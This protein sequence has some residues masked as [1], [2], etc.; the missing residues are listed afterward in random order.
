MTTTDEGSTASEAA[1]AA[2]RDVVLLFRQLRQ[3][4]REIPEGGLTSAQGAVLLRLDKD[5]PSSTTLLAAAEGVR[6]QSMTVTLNGLEAK[7][8]IERRPDP[9]DGRRAIVTLSDAGRD[10][11]REGRELRHLWLAQALDARL[12][13]EQLVAVNDSIT[14]LTHALSG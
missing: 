14:L 10:Q 8:L 3:R 2:A 13:P 4:M 1:S 11:V 7:G 12:A 5:G 6:S 9:A